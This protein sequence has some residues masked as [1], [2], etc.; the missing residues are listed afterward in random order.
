MSAGSAFFFSSPRGLG[1]IALLILAV[2]SVFFGGGA[3]R[4][5]DLAPGTKATLKRDPGRLLSADPGDNPLS[6]PAPGMKNG[7][8]A[9]QALAAPFKRQPPFSRPGLA[10]P[11]K[12]AL[13]F[14]PAEAPFILHKLGSGDGP[15]LLVVGGIQGDEPGGFSAAALLAS[16]YTIT[17]GSVWVVPDLN[18]PSILQRHRGLFGDMNRKFAALDPKDPEYDTV[19]RIKSVLLDKQVSLIL[20]LHDGSGFYRPTWEDSLRNPKRWGQSVIID[21]DAMETPV[22]PLFETACLVEADVNQALLDPRHRYHTHNTYTAD[23][24]VEMAKTLSWFAVC[25]GKPAFGIEASKE[26]GT[27]FRTYYHLNVIES[28][29]RRMGIGFKR[30]FPLSPKGVLSALN[31]GLLLTAFGDR[32]VLELDN[33]RP[34]LSMVPFKKE[35]GPRIRATKPLLALVPDRPSPGGP[36]GGNGPHTGPWRVAY[37]NRTLTRLEPL[38]VDFDD[39]LYSVSLLLDG[40]EALLP[41]GGAVTVRDSFMVLDLPGYRVNAIGAQREVNGTEAG[42]LLRLR[43]FM[44]RFSVDKGG[45]L[46]RVEIYKGKAFAGMIL[47]RF[48]DPDRPQPKPLTATGGKESSLGF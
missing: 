2:L 32:L 29:M 34:V 9:V 39:S 36:K 24:N 20:N 37:G 15:T 11:L 44:P 38:F 40:K 22:F 19:T 1:L 6:R 16:H 45:K 7:V 18:F 43:D 28:F 48:G 4:L 46:Y 23:G 35:S 41:V 25:N 30:D 3:L 10:R 12:E 31:S 47:V 14:A 42:V 13:P 21:Q 33:V 8:R 5:P 27:E 17:S 26:F